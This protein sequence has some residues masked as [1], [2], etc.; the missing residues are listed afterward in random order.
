MLR[1]IIRRLVLAALTLVLVSIIVF[2]AVEALPG[3]MATAYLGRDA[4]EEN[5]ALLREEYGLNRSMA[6]RYFDWFGGAIQGDLGDSIVRR[7]P[8]KAKIDINYEFK[9]NIRIHS[10][11]TVYSLDD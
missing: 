7:K 6:T 3:D 1:L 5:L 9:A 4:T 8:I 2:F 11:Q 10:L